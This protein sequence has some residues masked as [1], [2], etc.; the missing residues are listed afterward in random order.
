MHKTFYDL[1]KLLLSHDTLPVEVWTV[2]AGLSLLS[3]EPFIRFT[4]VA[5]DRITVNKHKF[6]SISPGELYPWHASI[7]NQLQG[8]LKST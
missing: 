1:L 4:S 6:L 5:G 2:R 3:A 7:L 8:E